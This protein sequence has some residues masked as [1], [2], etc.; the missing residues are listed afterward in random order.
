ME[1]PHLRVHRPKSA[2]VETVLFRNLVIL[3]DPYDF[4]GEGHLFD[5]VDTAQPLILTPIHPLWTSEL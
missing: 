4:S 5:I 3:F 2:Y 1:L